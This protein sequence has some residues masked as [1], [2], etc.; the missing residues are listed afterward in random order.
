MSARVGGLLGRF[1][2]CRIRVEDETCCVMVDGD[3]SCGGVC[4]CVGLEEK[5]VCYIKD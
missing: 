4:A 1:L 2:W 3:S 5:L